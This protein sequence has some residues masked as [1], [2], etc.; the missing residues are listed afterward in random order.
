MPRGCAGPSKRLRGR[1]EALATAVGGSPGHRSAR[2]FLCPEQNPCPLGPVK[3]AYALFNGSTLTKSE[4]GIYHERE[5]ARLRALL[6]TAAT[7]ALKAWLS[8]EAEKHEL[9][10]EGRYLAG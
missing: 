4:A 3:G 9:L 2:A 10:A 5:A 8:E 1:H 7:P 6:A